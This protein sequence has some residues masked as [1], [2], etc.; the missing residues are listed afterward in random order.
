MSWLHSPR[1]SRPRCCGR[2]WGAAGRPPKENEKQSFGLENQ[3]HSPLTSF[4]ALK[5]KQGY[6]SSE[7]GCALPLQSRAA[8]APDECNT[9]MCP[10]ET[11]AH[12]PGIRSWNRSTGQM[13]LILLS[14]AHFCKCFHI[15]IISAPQ[16]YSFTNKRRW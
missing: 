5:V 14:L 4:Q 3:T 11:T 7:P 15:F 6:G 10:G 13:N 12:H 9:G 16:K 8:L 1:L 2:T